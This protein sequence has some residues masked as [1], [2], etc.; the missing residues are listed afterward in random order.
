MSI[1]LLSTRRAGRNIILITIILRQS[2]SGYTY[3]K[4]YCF[5]FG[6]IPLA[7]LVTLLGLGL[8]IAFIEA[9]VFVVLTCSYV[10][11]GLDSCSD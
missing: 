8:G 4:C 6:L 11:H 1:W 5:L 7:F 3:S 10:K 2:I 9:Q